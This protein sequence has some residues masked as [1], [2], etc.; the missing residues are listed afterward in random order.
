MK[1]MKFCLLEHARVMAS[2]L[3][4]L[5]L[6]ACT[7]PVGAGTDD[8]GADVTPPANVMVRLDSA[9]VTLAVGRSRKLSA[10]VIAPNGN[11]WS[12]ALPVWRSLDPSVARVNA[13]G[14]IIAVSAGAARVVAELG[15]HADTVKVYVP[16]HDVSF[17]ALSPGAYT[18]QSLS[19][20]WPGMSSYTGIDRV[21]VIR[22]GTNRVLAVDYP[23]GSVGSGTSG[24]IWVVKF[25]RAY[26][27]M[28][29][30]YR[31]KFPPRFDPVLGG[32]LPGLAGGRGNTGG[33]H[34]SG[35]DGWSA[36]GMWVSAGRLIQYVYHKNQPS[37][38]GQTYRWNQSSGPSVLVPD[39]WHT[40]QHRIVMNTPGQPNGRV[41]AWLDGQL[42]LDARDLHFRDVDDLKIDQFQFS[43]F[44]GGATIQHGASRD[45]TILFDDFFISTYD[46]R[47]TVGL[48]P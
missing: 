34:P 17:D 40:M 22:E 14:L 30:R 47:V 25:P 8:R 44:F 16:L 46:P 42:V 11:V 7:E 48:K 36:R 32:K 9:A 12:G 38:Y 4:G 24:A 43:T 28:Y 5:A 18:T 2:L 10:T 19:V 13:K 3:V 21:R 26:D 37:I 27:E 15:G 20:D 39:R 1:A 23:S 6:V 31:V 41:Q 29:L 45:E 33:E 35:E